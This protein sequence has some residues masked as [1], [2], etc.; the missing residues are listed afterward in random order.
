MSSRVCAPTLPFVWWWWWWVAMVTRDTM[1]TEGHVTCLHSN[2]D[3]TATAQLVVYRYIP[4]YCRDYF[5]GSSYVST[6]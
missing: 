1:T 3:V 6:C 2:D 4:Y 5:R